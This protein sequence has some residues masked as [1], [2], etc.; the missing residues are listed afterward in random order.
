[1]VARYANGLRFQIQDEMS[2]HYVHNV[3]EAYQIVVRV[4][5]KLSRK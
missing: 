2:T 4:D 3:D 5:E 1:M